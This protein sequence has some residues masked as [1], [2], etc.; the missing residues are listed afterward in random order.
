M[1]K[2]RLRFLFTY[3]DGNLLW[4]NPTS[5]RVKI[6]EVAGCLTTNNYYLLSYDNNKRML[7]RV[8]WDYFNECGC[9]GFLVDHIDG[10]SMNNRIENLR[11][12]DYS[13]NAGNSVAH[14]D[15]QTGY[16]NI[17][18]Y[19]NGRFRVRLSRHGQRYDLGIFDD[20]NEAI[21]ARNQKSK[22]LYGSFHKEVY[23]K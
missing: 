7:H 10:N 5:N 18:P 15:N 13:Q 8:I 4:R 3:H 11:L 6:G 21:Q 1:S 14:E 23:Y 19:K 9:K 17:E 20:I 22:E 16:K 12:A 2:E